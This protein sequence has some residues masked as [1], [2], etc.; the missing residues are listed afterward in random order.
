[1][2][3]GLTSTAVFVAKFNKKNRLIVTVTN[4]LILEKGSLE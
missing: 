4:L 3:V 1:M 2:N